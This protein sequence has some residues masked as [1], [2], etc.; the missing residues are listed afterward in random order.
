M[1][2]IDLTKTQPIQEISRVIQGEGLLMGIPHIL[3]RLTGC[4]LRCQFAESFCDT[5]YASWKPEKGRFTLQDVIDFCETNNHVRHV[6]I[7]GGG[8]T[9]HKKLLPQ[10]VDICKNMQLFVTIETEGSE[11]VET[12]A[13][14]ISLSPN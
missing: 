10:V 9:M 7:T 4:K 2:E 5:W 8:P 12:N 14:L 1:S 6:F 3:I 11:F 13:D